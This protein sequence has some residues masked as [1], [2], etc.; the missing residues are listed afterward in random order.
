[1]ALALAYFR[2]G[3]VDEA[4]KALSES[5]RLNPDLNEESVIAMIGESAWSE[6]TSVALG[7]P[8]T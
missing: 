2:L 8:D 5:K 1:M 4:Q 3:Q 6:M 7:I